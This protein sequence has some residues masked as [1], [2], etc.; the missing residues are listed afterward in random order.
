MFDLS[1][2]LNN[3]FV[4]LFSF[5]ADVIS[6]FGIISILVLLRSFVSE[7][8]T[9]RSLRRF[10]SSFTKEHIVV[11]FTEYDPPNEEVKNIT[12]SNK[13]TSK[14]V[15]LGM[16]HLKTT[17]ET[18]IS[19]SVRLIGHT[20]FR[21]RDSDTSIII[22]GTPVAN[23]HA[24]DFLQRIKENYYFSFDIRKDLSTEEI[25]IFTGENSV[26]PKRDNK[27]KV[28]KDYALVVKAK[29]DETN[30]VLVMGCLTYGSYEGSRALSD[31]NILKQINRAL[32]KR[33]E[34]NCG[35]AFI[36]RTEVFD[37]ESRG[38][39]LEPQLVSVL[40]PKGQ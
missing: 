19:K 3:N 37:E 8:T 1:S 40:I 9:K 32:R 10:W 29:V 33:R 27:G 16:S 17:L 5:I 35:V 38:P 30:V 23:K 12:G 6:V 25:E 11:I 18:Y 21:L 13:L 28:S 2:F 14:G 22:I 15:G 31:G 7:S 24:Q 36:I 26:Q 4:K 39:R 20:Q 34:K